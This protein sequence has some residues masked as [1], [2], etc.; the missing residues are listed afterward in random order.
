M[1]LEAED[2]DLNKQ[3]EALF[4]VTFDQIFPEGWSAESLRTRAA[5]DA[6]WR[7]MEGVY[8]QHVHWDQAPGEIFAT[9]AEP[10]KSLLLCVRTKGA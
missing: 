1:F 7:H 3:A 6:V 9:M 5:F 2:R 10:L 4:D 8:E